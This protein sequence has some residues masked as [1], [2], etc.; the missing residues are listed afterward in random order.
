MEVYSAGEAPIDGASQSDLINGLVRHGHRNVLSIN[1]EDELETL[2]KQKAQSGDIVVFLGA[3]SISSWA[4]NLA[5][6]LN[7]F[8]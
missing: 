4:N 5:A 8:S 2:I 6:R 7:D 1:N 3:G